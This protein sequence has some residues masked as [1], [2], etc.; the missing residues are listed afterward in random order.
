MKAKGYSG[1][2]V[3]FAKKIDFEH[4]E[5]VEKNSESL[6]FNGLFSKFLKFHLKKFEKSIAIDR[7][8]K[9]KHLCSE[10]FNGFSFKLNFSVTLNEK[11]FF[12]K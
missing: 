11:L 12:L 9:L 5:I 2:P 7:Y 6:I 3:E 8:K 4:S 10:K 1:G